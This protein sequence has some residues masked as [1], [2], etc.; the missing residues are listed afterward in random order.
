MTNTLLSN[1][2]LL[3]YGILIGCGLILG[4]SVYYLIRSNYIANLPTNTEA[5]TNQEIEA[6]INENAITVTNNENIDA[7]IDDDSDFSTDVDSQSVSNLDWA[8]LSD[9]DEILADQELWFLPWFDGLLNPGE[10]I[11]PDVDF[12]ICP[13]EEL[14]LYELSSLFSREMAEHSVS[15]EDLRELISMFTVEDLA[16]NWINDAILCLIKLL[17]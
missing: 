1:N 2:N 8:S 5:L 11:M 15:E 7:I 10:F 14:K 6:I 17:E 12:N 9:F 13:I 3:D 16:T 4:C